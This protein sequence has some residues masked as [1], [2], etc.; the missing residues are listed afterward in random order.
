MTVRLRTEGENLKG[1]REHTEKTAKKAVPLK[2]AYYRIFAGMIVFPLLLV[3]LISLVALGRQYKGQA[4]E[5]IERAQET[6]ATELLSDV[7][8]MS[9]RLSQLIN[10]NDNM[11]I[12]YAVEVD[13]TSNDRKHEYQ[14]KLD[15]AG[16]LMMEPVKDI[17]SL[18]F[19]MKSGNKVFLKSEIKEPID[20]V[21]EKPWYQDAVAHPNSVKVG[22]YQTLGANDLYQGGS[23]DQLLLIY[24]IS[25]DT[26]IDRSQSVEAVVFY[27]TTDAGITIRNYNK[28]YEK[29]QNKLGIMQIVDEDGNLIFHS[30][31]GAEECGGGYTCVRTPVELGN[32]KWYVESYIKTSELMQDFMRIA[33]VIVLVAALIFAFASYFASYFLRQIV[34]P[35]GELSEG[36]KQIED[37][38]MDIHITPQGQAEI[39][40]VIHHFNAM[41]RSLK[42]LIEEYKEQAKRSGR[43]V[44]DYFADLMKGEMSAQQVQEDAPE[45]F[46]ER[47]AVVSLHLET[48]SGPNTDMDVARQVMAGFERNPRYTLHCV[49]YL[50][51]AQSAFLLYRVMEE[52]YQE[53]IQSMLRELQGYAARENAIEI[54]ASVGFACEGAQMF[55]QAVDSVKKY[56][57][58]RYLQG[59]SA[60]IDLDKNREGQERLLQKAQ[61]YAKLADTLY[62]A[63]DKNFA[64]EKERL[65]ENLNTGDR[66]EAE[67]VLYA[68]IL[69]VAFRFEPD[70]I[71][72]WDIFGQKYNY[73]DKI[74]R[75]EDIRS[76]KMWITNYLN[77]VM[78][79]SI[80]KIDMLETD[81]TVKAKRYLADHYDDAELTLA[82]VADYVGLNEKYFSNRFTKETGETFSNYL[83]QLRIQKA[84]E[85][86]RTTNFKS[87]EIAE[88]VG[89]RNAEHFTRMFKKETE[90]TPAQYRKRGEQPNGI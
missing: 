1:K 19:Y 85:L 26:M 6:V 32:T 57:G 47:Y 69:A 74:G 53:R 35:I 88:M 82:K 73:V 65:Y 89:Y 60:I 10:A 86:L 14:K 16:N 67:L 42:S 72:L 22:S 29:R 11:V 52:A 61:E 7:E 40:G 84:K 90:I 63:D 30:G 71:K 37:G 77:W 68:V 79:Y 83:T 15:Q 3:L 9:M 36:L 23:R 34:N 41:A 20:E 2:K 27:Q 31:E 59:E 55:E 8:F 44:A 81:V 51:N 43:G 38:K 4:I 13:S 78:D 17:I 62:G 18:A 46:A 21:R 56:D 25:P 75:L 87:Y 12:R 80:S 58:L 50:Q 48:A 33:V 66:S 54:E 24:A 28:N 70:G 39:R 64:K 76:M 5:N 49:G 45:F